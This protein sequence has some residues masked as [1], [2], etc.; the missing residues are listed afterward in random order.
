M[1]GRDLKR[2]RLYSLGIFFLPYWD[3]ARMERAK[4]HALSEL[5][6]RT[7]GISTESWP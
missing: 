7:N 2:R 5:E 3:L 1:P 6:S 4:S